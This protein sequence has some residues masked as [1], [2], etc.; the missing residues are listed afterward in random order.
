MKR[1]YIIIPVVALF[2]LFAAFPFL[3]LKGGEKIRDYVFREITYRVISDKLVAENDSISANR[4]YLYVRKHLKM[5]DPGQLVKDYNALETLKSGI[6]SCDQQV[7]VMITL[8][9]V[10][11]I[12]GRMIFLYGTDSISHHTTGEL[13]INEKWC[14]YDP[15]Y[16]NVFVNNH[17]EIVS[18]DGIVK[19]RAELI[20]TS[21]F[22]QDYYNL[23]APKYDFRIFMDNQP[24]LMRTASRILIKLWCRI[25]NKLILDRYVEAYFESAKCDTATITKLRELLFE[26]IGFY[27]FEI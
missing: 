18:V 8:A 6:A 27:D 12:K 4:I 10:C 7:D 23:F 15:F 14:M 26:D 22:D 16:G 25:L 20:D 13:K 19:S 24:G 2:G 5:P 11:G 3:S 21:H 1:R 17:G 9:A